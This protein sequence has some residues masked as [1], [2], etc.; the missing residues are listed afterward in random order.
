MINL[1]YHPIGVIHS[2]FKETAGMPIQAVAAQGI[3]GT[4]DLDPDYRDGLKDIEGFSHLILLYHLHLVQSSKLI[5]IPFLDDEPHGIFATR[6][7]R[8][9]N[10]IG[11]SIVR[12]MQVEDVTLHI[13]DIDIAD[14]SPLI[15]I[16]PYV[17]AFD[18]RNDV[19][20]GWFTNNIARMREVRSDDHS[21][22]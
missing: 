14:G 18:E 3:A 11:L 4:I 19:R 2:P 9:P 1:S 16:K 17:P 5:V 7:P 6:A 13:Q 15:D 8:R 20:I 10:P 22:G 12:L 21:K